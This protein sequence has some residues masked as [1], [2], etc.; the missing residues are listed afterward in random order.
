MLVWIGCWLCIYCSILYCFPSSLQTKMV[1]NMTCHVS[2]LVPARFQECHLESH[3]IANESDQMQL[4]WV[5][6][7]NDKLTFLCPYLLVDLRI[8]LIFLCCSLDLFQMNSEA[9]VSILV[10]DA[11]F[12]SNPIVCPCFTFI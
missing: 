5:I 3:S 4:L 9:Y 12:I 8:A 2:Q 7:R 1:K 10:I 11:R 6:D